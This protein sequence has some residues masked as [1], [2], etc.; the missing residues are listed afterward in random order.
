MSRVSVADQNWTFDVT[1]DEQLLDATVIFERSLDGSAI[2]DT[3]LQD[4]VEV[5]FEVLENGTERGGKKFVSSDSFSYTQKEEAVCTVKVCDEDVA[6]KVITLEADSQRAKVSL[7]RESGT[8]DVR[9]GDF[10]TITDVVTLNHYK[11]EPSLSTT[12]RSTLKMEEVK[13]RDNWRS[14]CNCDQVI[15]DCGKD[16][17]FC[18][19]FTSP[20]TLVTR[21]RDTVPANDRVTALNEDYL[22]RRA[23]QKRVAL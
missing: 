6:I 18:R 4:P 2:T 11:G 17:G 16:T 7:W 15:T 13:C 8:S 5:R 9:P 10:M 21:A 14:S 12:N 19:Y 1:R 23:N 3:V 20:R 22:A